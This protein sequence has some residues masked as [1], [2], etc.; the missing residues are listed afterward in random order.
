MG[1]NIALGD[2]GVS[3][4]GTSNDFIISG[5]YFIA[6]DMALIAGLGLGINGGD[7]KGTDLGFT[8]GARKY[9]KSDDLAPFVGARFAYS[10]TGDSAMPGGKTVTLGLLAEAGA[11]YFLSKQFSLEGRVGFGYLSAETTTGAAAA[12]KGTRIGTESLGI[13]ANFYF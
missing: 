10:T 2:K 8:V 3:G 7:A 1:L 5:K 6:K 4:T 13:S 12:F 9:L 11:E